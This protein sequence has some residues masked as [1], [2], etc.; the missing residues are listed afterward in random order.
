MANGYRVL[1][2]Y[3][4]SAGNN[5][6]ERILH[7]NA[8]RIDE[9]VAHPEYLI[10]KGEYNKLLKQQAKEELNARKHALYDRV[11]A[12]IDFANVSRETLIVKSQEKNIDDL[13]EK[14]FEKT[15]NSIQ[16]ISKIES[17][18]WGMIGNYITAIDNQIR[19]IVQNDKRISDYYESE[20][21]SKIKE[22]CNLLTQSQREF[23]EYITEK[24]QL[25]SQLFGR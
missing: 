19:E 6:G 18:E 25:I 23:N 9:L 22:T 20:A 1:I 12:I 4:T 5:R 17:D 13:V 3:I 10:S 15:V 7:I 16:R 2:T 8:S 14:L 21:F 24:T 11:N